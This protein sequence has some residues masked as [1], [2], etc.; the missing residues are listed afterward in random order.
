MSLAVTRLTPSHVSAL[1]SFLGNPDVDAIYAAGDNNNNNNNDNNNKLERY[2]TDWMGA[3]V[4]K[5]ELCVRP[6][7]TAEVSK[8]LRYC[9][10]ERIAVVPQG[11][12]TGLV[13]GSVPIRDE[14]VMCMT[15]M[16]TIMDVNPLERYAVV[17]AGV[18]LE[19]LHTEAQKQ[20]MMVPWDLGAK[21]SCTVGGNVATNAGG[22][23]TCRYG[24][25]RP[26]I[27]GLEVVKAD[28]TVLDMLST[29]RKDNTGYDVKSLFIGSEGTLG[30]VTKVVLGLVPMPRSVQVIAHRVAGFDTAREVLRTAMTH[31]GPSLSAFEMFDHVAVDIQPLMAG[32]A[33]MGLLGPEG[34]RDMYVLLET[35]GVDEASDV[36]RLMEYQDAIAESGFADD[37]AASVMGESETH[38]KMLWHLRENITSCLAKKGTGYKYDVTLPLDVFYRLV[39]DVR[40]QVDAAG[41]ADDVIVTGYGHMADG[42]LHLNLVDTT[43]GAHAAALDKVLNPFVYDFVCKHHGSISA[44]HGIGRVKRDALHRTKD[45]AVMAEMRALKQLFDPTGI[46]NPN[47][48]V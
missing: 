29:L 25:V 15:N 27:L 1:R 2:N 19:A 8:I 17:E 36:E 41:I 24:T 12:N 5:S 43:R 10:E 11:G 48:V 32:D 30:V 45:A 9:N 16:N 20:D 28:G 40:R 35:H 23:R 13:G 44:E 18:V 7:T 3:I 21:G 33:P 39:Q 26:N 6:R 46:L 4:G 38:R 34:C 22:L 37:V 31:L 14:V 42:N 47:K